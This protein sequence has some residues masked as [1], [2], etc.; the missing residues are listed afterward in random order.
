MF[1]L[2]YSGEHWVIDTVV[3]IAYAA[4]VLAGVTAIER[5]ARR[6]RPHPTSVAACPAA[7]AAMHVAAFNDDHATARRRE[8]G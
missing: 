1:T 8:A 7:D 2:V 6:D 4:V 5:A 3:G